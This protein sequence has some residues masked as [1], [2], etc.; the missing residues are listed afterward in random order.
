MKRPMI[1]L[2][3]ASAAFGVAVAFAQPPES[4]VSPAPVGA[5]SRATVPGDAARG[6]LVF[7]PCRTCHYPDKG[8]GHQNGPSLWNIFGRR[9][10]TQ[11]G[12]AGY[13]EALTQSGI[14]WTPAYLDAWLA[15]PLHFIAGTSMMTPGVADPQ[16]RAD[17][18]A[19]LQQF[20]EPAP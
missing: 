3:G 6:R 15:D 2:L 19:Y 18:I 5:R 1:A 16:A 8:A 13:S 10:G 11:E 12:F 14:V 9:A 4:S 7:G 20:R 17:L